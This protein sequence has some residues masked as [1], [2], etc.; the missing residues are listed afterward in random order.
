MPELTESSLI[1]DLAR[2]TVRQVAPQ[3]LPRFRAASQ[4]Y[5]EDPQRALEGEPSKDQMLGF[6][7]GHELAF[8]TPIVLAMATQVVQFVFDEVASS[9]KEESPAVIQAFVQKLFKRLRPAEEKSAQ[10]EQ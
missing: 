9:L 1:A 6:G 5:F 4:A 8:I 2:D 10:P 3:E 7:T